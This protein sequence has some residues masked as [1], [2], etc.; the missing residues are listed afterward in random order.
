MFNYSLPLTIEEQA[1]ILLYDRIR[2]H[3]R[4]TTADHEAVVTAIRDVI[5]QLGSTWDTERE[6][7]TNA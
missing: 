2:S 3:V 1:A 6:A 5:S 7:E 4:D